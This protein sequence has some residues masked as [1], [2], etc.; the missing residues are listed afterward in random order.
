MTIDE[1]LNALANGE[2]ARRKITIGVEPR[3]KVGRIISTS[4]NYVAEITNWNL[5]VRGHPFLR[6]SG[7][8]VVWYEKADEVNLEPPRTVVILLSE[9]F[10]SDCY[11][12]P[13]MVTSL[14]PSW[15]NGD[16]QGAQ[17]TFV[18]A[19]EFIRLSETAGIDLKSLRK[20]LGLSSAQAARQ[21][22][23]TPRTWLRWESGEY[24]IPAGVLKLF[25][26]VNGL[27]KPAP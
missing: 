1:S 10:D 27:E 14:V 26:I 4:G 17:M 2:F 13:I 24:Q 20:S 18:G 19:G 11:G 22:E 3:G 6:W 25:R 16:I 7:E 5:E 12:G 15:K 21:V 23:V 8:C 9:R